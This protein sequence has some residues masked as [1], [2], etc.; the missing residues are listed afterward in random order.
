M[1]TTL[2]LMGLMV[3][4]VASANA[5]PVQL[6]S[7][8]VTENGVTATLVRYQDTMAQC[9]NYGTLTIAQ[10]GQ[11]IDEKSV[12][13]AV[14]LLSAVQGTQV[15]FYIYGQDDKGLNLYRYVT[16]R[17]ELA[18]YPF[19]ANGLKITSL[20]NDVMVQ[21]YYPQQT[22]KGVIQRRDGWTWRYNYP[23]PKPIK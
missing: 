18:M 15:V 22:D 5:M 3:A 13:G 23:A 11:V 4:G 2:T 1:K 9:A 14:N 8:T 20:G 7:R 17:K 21:A 12:C 10:K 19:E 16:E 6:D